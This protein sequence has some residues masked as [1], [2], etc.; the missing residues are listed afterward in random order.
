MAIYELE[1]TALELHPAQRV[2]HD[3]EGRGKDEERHRRETARRH[4]LLE[5]AKP[6]LAFGESLET[7]GQCARKRKADAQG[8]E[9]V[10]GIGRHLKIFRYTTGG[11][12][13]SQN[14]RARATSSLR[15]G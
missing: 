11:S 6:G 10:E 14:P 5:Q 12:H 15:K 1:A 9:R 2:A 4:A 13:L 8:E 3:D 7:V